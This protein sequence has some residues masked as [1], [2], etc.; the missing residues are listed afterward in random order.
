MSY[1]YYVLNYS[2]FKAVNEIPVV[3]KLVASNEIDGWYRNITDYS[4]KMSD[5]TTEITEDEA[6]EL[7]KLAEQNPITITYLSNNE[8]VYQCVNN[9]IG[10]TRYFPELNVTIDGVKTI[11]NLFHVVFVSDYTV[12]V[13]E[14]FKSHQSIRNNP[15]YVWSAT[16]SVTV[17]LTTYL[18]EQ[19]K[20]RYAF[21]P[22]PR[23]G[24]SNVVLD[25]YLPRYLY[26]SSDM[27]I[28]HDII[29]ELPRTAVAISPLTA[30][31]LQVKQIPINQLI[32]ILGYT[33]KQIK[34]LLSSVK[35]KDYKL[36]FAGVGGTGINT[37]MWLYNLCEMTNTVNLFKQVFIYE[38]ETVELSNIFRF[39]LLPFR[40]A[41]AL[42]VY[43]TDLIYPYAT[44]L[45]RNE[46]E[47]NYSYIGN[48]NYPYKIYEA[49]YNSEGTYTHTVRPKVI[50]Y[51]APSLEDRNS[52]SKAGSF[53]SATHA[54]TSCTLYLN[55][56]QDEGIQVE[57]YGMIQLNNFFMNQL[58]M[59]IKFLEFLDSDPDLSEQDKHIH[60]SAFDGT[61]VGQTDRVYN[62]QIAPESV[63]LTDQEAAAQF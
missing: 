62:F 57:S 51:G 18:K 25:S 7:I 4:L 11:L 43:K 55:P 15:D 37:I 30:H 34:R 50:I 17:S 47:I 52:L 61:T 24:L 40:T 32:R 13:P 27:T 28:S 8:R 2:S 3:F 54:D 58:M 26:T 10:S 63:M 44:K 60:T 36:V 46:L 21:I 56:H 45:S 59:T 39:P 38:K 19:I 20:A 29:K 1:K 14:S 49:K 53:I 31:L 23:N 16:Q 33:E 42:R 5:I 22:R 9:I 6:N 48:D 12:A 41:K 35:S